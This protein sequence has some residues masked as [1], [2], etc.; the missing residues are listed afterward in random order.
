MEGV[1]NDVL[2][3]HYHAFPDRQV[4]SRALEVGGDYQWRSEGEGHLFSPQVI[5]S[6]KK[7]VRTGNYSTFNGAQIAVIPERSAASLG[8]LGMLCLLRRR[9]Q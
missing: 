5:H 1:A 8:G 3:R 2:S 7:A 9:R 6:L 4:T